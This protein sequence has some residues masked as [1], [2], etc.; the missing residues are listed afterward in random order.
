M[1]MEEA[2]ELAGEFEAAVLAIAEGREPE[3]AKHVKASV[4]GA[5]TEIQAMYDRRGGVVLREL[6]ASDC[7]LFALQEVQVRG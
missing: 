1:Q 5:V 4:L 6:L 7:D 2:L 3:G